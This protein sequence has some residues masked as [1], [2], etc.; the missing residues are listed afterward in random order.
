[1]EEE[2][3]RHLVRVRVSASISVSISVSLGISFGFGTGFN[4]NTDFATLLIFFKGL[5]TELK[6]IFLIK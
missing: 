2:G 4:A 6:R 3:L 1:M 5:I